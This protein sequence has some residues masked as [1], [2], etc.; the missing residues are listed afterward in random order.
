MRI[1]LSIQY[2]TK[3]KNDLPFE[4]KARESID[5]V[6]ITSPSVLVVSSGN[7]ISKR[8]PNDV[9]YVERTFTIQEKLVERKISLDIDTSGNHQF[10]I[11]W[12]F[13]VELWRVEV[14]DSMYSLHNY[15]VYTY[16]NARIFSENVLDLLSQQFNDT[17]HLLIEPLTEIDQVFDLQLSGLIDRVRERSYPKSLKQIDFLAKDSTQASF[18]IN[19]LN[20][21]SKFREGLTK[22]STENCLYWLEPNIDNKDIHAFL[23]HASE[24]KS[25]VERFAKMLLSRK[26]HAWFDKWE[27]KVGDSIV[28]KIQSGLKQMTHLVVFLSKKSINKPWV[29]REMMSTISRAIRNKSIRIIILKLEDVVIP[30]IIDDLKYADCTLDLE[31]G[32]NQAIDDMVAQS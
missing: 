30:T 3:T 28:E 5:E 18:I 11:I 25:E 23:C 32:F 16:D 2:L 31:G 14:F 26:A 7:E 19:Y 17:V 22:D 21:A 20:K 10:N 4:E 24:D 9:K 8:L 1:R 15:T 29:E 13:Y 12:S 6:K 27:I